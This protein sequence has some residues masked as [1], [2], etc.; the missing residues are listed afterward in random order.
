VRRGRPRPPAKEGAQQG[1]L[2]AQ[3]L[4]T[5]TLAGAGVLSTAGTQKVR[6][7]QG[8]RPAPKYLVGWR[9][10]AFSVCTQGADTGCRHR[11]QRQ[12]ADAGCRAQGADTG[13]RHRV[14]TQGADTGCRHRVQTQGADTGCRHRCKQGEGRGRSGSCNELRAGTPPAEEK[15]EV[16][17]QHRARVQYCTIQCSHAVQ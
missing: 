10:W 3:A 6:A 1:G 8:M 13:C 17:L 5:N 7:S 15:A 9:S 11:V 4:G 14:Q 2:K 16:L 12:G